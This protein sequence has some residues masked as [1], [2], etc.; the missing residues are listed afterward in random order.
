MVRNLSF[1]ATRRACYCGYVVQAIVN[2]LAPLFFIIFSERYGISYRGLGSL[3][4]INFAVQ[5]GVDALCIKLVSPI[6]YRPLLIAAQA[7]SAAGLILLGIL[8]LLVKPVYTA[9]VI[10]VTVYAFGGGLLEVLV[11]PVVDSIPGEADR[12]PAAMSLLHSFYCWGQMGVILLSTLLLSV[13]GLGRWYILPLLWALVPLGNMLLFAKV[14]LMRTLPDTEAMGL[15]G[16]AKSPAFFICLLMM[17]CAGASEQA[18]AQWASLFAEKALGVPKVLGDILGP[19]LFAL[20]MGTGRT[21][22]GIWGAKLGV[23]PSML[24]CASL[25]ILCYLGITLVPLPLVQLIACGLTGLSVSVMWPAT[26][27]LSSSRFPLGG[28][29]LFAVLALMGDLGCSLGP[30]TVGMVTDLRLTGLIGQGNSPLQAG[31]LVCT[32]FPLVFALG[33]LA[34]KKLSRKASID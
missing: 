33:V 5:L 29:A 4:M 15:R 19:A 25:C 32:L 28:V 2:N 30:W 13:I 9:L 20:F 24:F 6:G 31:I 22:Y 34:L 3:V 17:L 7:F 11:S 12:K 27:S 23:F 21:V 16:L 18:V 8:P 1:R 26:L 10:A 14:P